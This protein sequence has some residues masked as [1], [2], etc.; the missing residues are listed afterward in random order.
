MFGA[1]V[2]EMAFGWH[3]SMGRSV[4]MSTLIT[5]HAQCK[6]AQCKIEQGNKAAIAKLRTSNYKNFHVELCAVNIHFL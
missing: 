6:I 2:S 5:E 1:S 4:Q 3:C